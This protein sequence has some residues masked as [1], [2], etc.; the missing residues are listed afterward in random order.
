MTTNKFK[1][2]LQRQ[3]ASWD[4]D[5]ECAIDRADETVEVIK[6]AERMAIDLALPEV[7]RK[8][9]A[10]TTTLLALRPAQLFLCELVAMLP[11]E[12]TEKEGMLSLRAASKL[13]G[14]TESGLRKLVDKKR[15]EYFQA[16]RWGP[17]KFK[18]EWLDSFVAGHATAAPRPATA[19]RSSHGSNWN[20]R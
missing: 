18:R 2:W 6:Q 19:R 7:A 12:P 14:Y 4:D 16:K 10:V 5:R 17:I 11:S 9:N 20:C 13:L 15:I 3:I 1:S 8:C